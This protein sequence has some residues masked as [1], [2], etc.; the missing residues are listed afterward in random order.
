MRLYDM[1]QRFQFRRYGMHYDGRRKIA[2]SRRVSAGT[3]D[4]PRSWYEK[5]GLSKLREAAHGPNGR[6]KSN[7][8]WQGG[9]DD[10]L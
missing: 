8:G 1:H 3:L 10:V 5:D 6:Y 4:G 2:D 7:V 9:A